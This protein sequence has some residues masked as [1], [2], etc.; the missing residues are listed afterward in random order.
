MTRFHPAAARAPEGTPQENRAPEPTLTVVPSPVTHA[1]VGPTVD[2]ASNPVAAS[3]P[4][5][6]ASAG[7]EVLEL[8]NVRI[9]RYRNWREAHMRLVLCPGGRLR[10][11]VH[12]NSKRLQGLLGQPACREIDE[13]RALQEHFELR[14]SE[15]WTIGL[16]QAKTALHQLSTRIKESSKAAA[17]DISA[18]P[19]AT[20]REHSPASRSV[21]GVHAAIA[22]DGEAHG[23]LVNQWEGGASGFGIDIYDPSHRSLIRIEGIDLLR[24]LELSGAEFGDVIRVRQ[25]GTR[26]I[27]V[28]EQR[29]G[30]HGLGRRVLHPSRLVYQIEC[31]SPH[32]NASTESAELPI[33]Q[34]LLGTQ[35]RSQHTGDEQ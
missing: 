1:P 22:F 20:S 23:L 25:V 21:G 17:G 16:A 29:S 33:T 30:T 28:R 11:F 31:D 12:L 14:T 19:N 8:A 32:A 15:L 6:Q 27:A 5:A 13:L 7:L 35:A 10:R 34:D 3:A 24:A 9:V 4:S 26:E 18:L 2:S